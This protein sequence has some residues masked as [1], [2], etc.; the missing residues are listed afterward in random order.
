MP[1]QTDDAQKVIEGEVDSFSALQRTLD[2]TQAELMANPTFVK[3]L[4]LTKEVKAADTAMRA[5]LKEVM[6]ATK[7]KSF[8]GDFG[9]IT[10]KDRTDYKVDTEALPNKFFKR[11]PDI[12]KIKAAHTLMDELPKGVSQEHSQYIE[13][14]LKKTKEE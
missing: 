2:S 1:T 3:Y 5:K 13:I 12:D 4:E 9:S 11:V 6:A 10:L 14:R 8:K 7:T